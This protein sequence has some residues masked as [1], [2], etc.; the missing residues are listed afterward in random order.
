[1]GRQAELRA[2]R[3]QLADAGRG[4][5]GLALLAGEPGIG[6]T[7][8]VAELAERAERDGWTVLAGHAYDT[9]GMP[10]YL[11]FR[12]ALQPYLRDCPLD[13]LTTLLG[14]DASELARL[15]PEVHAR[16][17][18]P[19][20][21]PPATPAEARYRLFEAVSDVLLRLARAPGRAGLLLC[22]DDLHWADEATLLLLEHLGRRLAGAPL[23]VVVAY[24]DTEVAANPHLAHT[25]T[26][27]LRLPDV[28]VQRLGLARLP[29]AAVAELLRGL[30]AR[31]PPAALVDVLV[32]QTEGNPFF[33]GELYHSLAEAGRL[34]D[35]AGA[36]RTD[37]SV[38]E[39][40]VPHTVR[41]VIEQRLGRLSAECRDVL[42]RAAVIGRDFAFSLLE[43][44]SDGGALEAVEEAQRASLVH[45][46]PGGREA[47]YR[48]AHELI[49]QTMLAGLARPR[50]QRLHLRVAQ[51]LAPTAADPGGLA[52]EI[53]YHLFEAGEAA[54][55]GETVRYLTL[56]A[57]QAVAIAAVDE[58]LQLYEKALRVV[59]GMAPGDERRA[60]DSEL[61][62]KRG[63]AYASLGRWA[64]ARAELE[65]ALAA[66]PEPDA[67]RAELLVH[68][69]Q[70][71]FWSLD[72]P[73]DQ[74][75]RHA[76][77]AVALARAVARP[78]LV[79]AAIGWQ[80]TADSAAGDLSAAAGGFARALAQAE[81]AAVAAPPFA[82]QY[83]SLLLY[84]TGRLVEATRRGGEAIERF[85]QLNDVA[86]LVIV[87]PSQGLALAARGR[88]EEAERN[89]HEAVQL[90]RRHGI[91]TSLARA[92]AMSAG[93]HLDTF[94]YVG[95][96]ELAEEARDV[97]RTF[98]HAPPLISAAIDLLFLCARRHD[99]SRVAELATEVEAGMATAGPWHA[100]G[101]RIRY[102]QARAEIALAR[103]DW[104]E[105]LRLSE[106]TMAQSQAVGRRRYEVMALHTGAAAL[107]GLGRSGEAMERLRRA[108]DLARILGDPALFL[109][110]AVALL[111]YAGDPKLLAEATQTA[112]RLADALPDQTWLLRFQ[113]AAT[114]HR[115]FADGR[116]PS[117]GGRVRRA[118]PAY[119]DHLSEREVE[120][121]R[122]IAA[123]KSNPQIAAALVLST[124]T[125]ERHVTHILQKTSAA[126]RAAAAAYATH[127]GLT[128]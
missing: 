76:D 110:P 68:L 43:A 32:A 37:F 44:V 46:T 33:L 45:G 14:G 103:R 36:W 99:L 121:L 81:E 125:V 112:H 100:W 102:S 115:F 4:T 2:L 128:G 69:C 50:R 26:Q 75:H 51:A 7:R 95:A 91:S 78:D 42:A 97:A 79:V 126:N 101:W 89:F 96:E 60:L 66:H 84:W 93:P 73:R 108:L 56:A 55:A 1:V 52:A 114:V 65:T 104:S 82:L 11:P 29:P 41:L 24:R 119:P 30:S 118:A 117:A 90:G 116:P 72:D 92:I 80:A 5:G 19:A 54:E 58:G 57:D 40:D 113:E 124:N 16:L 31:E 12:E 107:S 105:A 123:G 109:R 63:L 71:S 34:V 21:L 15:L 86:G 98:A 62:A 28:G 8:L 9:A 61:R 106:V 122:L 111:D 23:L 22:L 38:V 64:S 59:A 49:R 87:L 74:L 25:L 13:A 18:H 85:R 67:R 83:F 17:P 88:Y 3:R 48:F 39:G 20:A 70:S 127:H 77:E 53:A 10:P 35:A 6:K 94:D 27:L 120:V 47:R